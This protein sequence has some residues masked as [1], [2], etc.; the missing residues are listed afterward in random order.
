M[1]K[2]QSDIV[3]ART[4]RTYKRAV[5]SVYIIVCHIIID[6][7]VLLMLAYVITHQLLHLF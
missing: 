7:T 3:A 4:T 6:I 2:T 1:Q 5:P